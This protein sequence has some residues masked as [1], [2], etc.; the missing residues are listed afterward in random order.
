MN[1]AAQLPSSCLC[2]PHASDH[3]LWGQAL[4]RPPLWVWLRLC[5]FP[6]VPES[7][8]LHSSGRRHLGRVRKAQLRGLHVHPTSGRVP[9]VPALDGPQRPPQLLPSCSPGESRAP[10]IPLLHSL[11]RL[12]QLSLSL[13]P[14]SPLLFFLTFMWNHFLN[15]F[16]PFNGVFSSVSCWGL[17]KT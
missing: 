4:S 6:H 12:L 10:P 7:L 15:I 8:Q 3:F 17:H 5:R 11:A 13:S 9:R 1:N 2:S 16:L 14:T